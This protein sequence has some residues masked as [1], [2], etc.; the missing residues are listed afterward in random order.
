MHSAH[1]LPTQA[2][3]LTAQLALRGELRA[4][5][6]WPRGAAMLSRS[7]GDLKTFLAGRL[8][9]DDVDHVDAGVPRA[10]PAPGDE[11]G[12]G[13]R[14]AF[15]VDRHAAVRF[16]AR[17]AADAAPFGFGAGRGAKPDALHVA[18][19]PH[20]PSFDH[21]STFHETARRQDGKTARTTRFPDSAEDHNGPGSCSIL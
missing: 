2:A 20:D 7:T 3:W 13:G 21:R 6:R 1:A 12:E 18:G 16:V 11:G 8:G 5:P 10:A 19:H 9:G 14:V 4:G 15:G 17:P